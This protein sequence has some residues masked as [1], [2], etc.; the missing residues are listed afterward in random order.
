MTAVA[1]DGPAGAGKS[2]VARAVATE[3]GFRYVDTG[4]MYRAV[5]LAALESGVDPDDAAALGELVGRIDIRMGER[6]VHL[7]GRDVTDRLRGKE[8]T[9]GAARVARHEVVRSSLV[10]LQRDLASSCDVVMEG[11]DIG[12]AVIPEA[13]VKIFLPA[14]LDERARRRRQQSG[15]SEASHAEIQRDI[16]RRDRSDMDRPVSPLIQA[17]DAEVVD[18]TG[19]SLE[20]VVAKV[21][22]VARRQMG[23]R[24]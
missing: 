19:L 24:S 7:D 17:A 4:A 3:L 18:T 16:E 13:E 8:V 1:I 11:R 6:T 14:S 21:A 15:A 5:A 12:S 10:G 2:S 23:Q 9:A 20:Q 22:S